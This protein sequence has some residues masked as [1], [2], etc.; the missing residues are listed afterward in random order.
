LRIQ[1][2][3]WRRRDAPILAF[4]TEL[5]KLNTGGEWRKRDGGEEQIRKSK[6]KQESDAKDSRISVLYL[7]STKWNIITQY[8]LSDPCK[9]KCNNYCK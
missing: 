6:M 5:S 2:G 3:T 7:K 8:V 9:T 1:G 4:P